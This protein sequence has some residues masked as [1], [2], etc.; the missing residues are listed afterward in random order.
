MLVVRLK[1]GSRHRQ[2]T[3]RNSPLPRES[4]RGSD[5]ADSFFLLL[6]LL[7][8]FNIYFWIS[9]KARDQE[10]GN[11]FL[12]QQAPIIFRTGS[13]DHLLG[14]HGFR[15]RL[16]SGKGATHT[17][18][19]ALNCLQWV[20]RQTCDQAPSRRPPLLLPRAQS[21]AAWLTRPRVCCWSKSSAL[22][23]SPP[24]C[25]CRRPARERPRWPR[26][27]AWRVS[28]PLCCPSGQTLVACGLPS[29]RMRP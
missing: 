23:V 25:V 22:H 14:C 8:F 3:R 6:F 15:K 7:H 24:T 18:D 13:Q 20:A 21:C 1:Y 26:A 4:D 17:C 16:A 12:E 29:L 9:N 2:N 11:V 19:A 28:L 27:T 10:P 5:S